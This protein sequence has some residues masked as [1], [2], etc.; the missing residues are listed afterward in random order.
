[1]TDSLE[2]C[3]DHSRCSSMRHPAAETTTSGL[4]QRPICGMSGRLSGQA[5]SATAK[6]PCLAGT[7]WYV[8]WDCL[9]RRTQ[10]D[11]GHGLAADRIHPPY[12]GAG[13]QWPARCGQP[14][15]DHPGLFRLSVRGPRPGSGDPAVVLWSRS[16][17]SVVPARGPVW[18]GIRLS[19]DRSGLL[20]HGPGHGPQDSRWSGP[21]ARAIPAWAIRWEATCP[22]MPSAKE[23]IADHLANRRVRSLIIGSRVSQ[24]RSAYAA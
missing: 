4:T 16:G 19:V 6:C 24:A 23:Q 14:A 15:G 12:L 11:Y 9:L 8:W 3:A 20:L 7:C 1:M 17:I 5:R 22:A 21:A 2:A 18:P 10:R 13:L